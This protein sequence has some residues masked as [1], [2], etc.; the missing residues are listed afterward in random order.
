[1]SRHSDILN[2]P[3]AALLIIDMQEKF[4]PTIPD[5]ALIE[6][7]IITLIKACRILGVPFLY[8]E[9]YPKG[10]GRTTAPLRIELGDLAS[11][12]KMHFSVAGEK[13][14]LTVLQ[15]KAISQL[16][17]TGIETHVCVLQSA[18]D[19]SFMNY[20]VHVVR[21]ATSSRRPI[22]YDNAL[23]R[24]LQKGITISTVESVLF[25]LTVVAG[26]EEFRQIAKLV[27]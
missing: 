26:T 22:D 14:L 18:L 27:K 21:N 11:I 5:Y 13:S 10:L 16:I 1:M 2:R 19:F 25:E 12:E 20:Q 17:L 7:N 15:E 4:V 9:Q 8:T 23:Q 3:K 6:G 24:M